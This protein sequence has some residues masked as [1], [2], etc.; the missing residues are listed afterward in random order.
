MAT[1]E[2]ELEVFSFIKFLCIVSIPKAGLKP[3]CELFRVL[4]AAYMKNDSL[5]A[6]TLY[7]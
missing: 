4:S 5:S 7:K 1:L 2:Y 6:K 3:E